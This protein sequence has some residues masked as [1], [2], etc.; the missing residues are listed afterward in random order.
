VYDA[1]K[2]VKDNAGGVGVDKQTTEQFDA[3]LMG[4]L[5][6]IRNR[7]SSG[8][9]FPSPVRAVPIPKKNGGQR[10]LGVPTVADRVAQMVVKQIV[11]RTNLDASKN[12]A[13]FCD[14]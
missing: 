8:S 6:K 9:Y 4:N 7:Q 14:F 2:A 13:N 11:E 10:I 1:Y 5:Y 12:L 3:D